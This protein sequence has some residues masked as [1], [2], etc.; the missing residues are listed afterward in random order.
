M[1]GTLVVQLPCCEGHTGGSLAVRHRRKQYVHDFAQDSTTS[2]QYAAF[3]ADCEHEL[4]PL[5]GG[6]R[7]VLAYNLVFRG[8]AAAAPRLAGCSAA[9]RQLKAAV[10]A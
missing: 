2:T 7:L 1:I 4:T 10:Q 9:E 6:M 3:F 5:T 8:P